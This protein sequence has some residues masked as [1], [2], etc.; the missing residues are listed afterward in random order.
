MYKQ[1]LEK[2]EQPEIKLPTFTESRRK[3]ANSIKISTSAPLITLKP[4]TVQITT[5]CGKFL[6]REEYQITLLVSQ[7][8]CMQAKKRQFE[9][10]MEQ[11]TGSKLGKECDMAMYCHPAYLTYMRNAGLDKSQTEIKIASRNIN[12]L[13]Y[14][15]DIT[16][17]AE[18]EEELKSFLKVKEE[19][20]KSWLKTQH[21]KN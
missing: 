4:L 18:S 1:D 11:W 17:M 19:S 14:E 6:E 8:T 21:S 10:D 13:R 5:N 12:N 9:L 3:Q 2:S 15:D 7:E 20:G 16:L